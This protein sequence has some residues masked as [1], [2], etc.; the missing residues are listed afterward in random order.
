MITET[1]EVY[2]C[3]Y[4]RK[5][6]QVKRFAELHEERCTKNPNNK[7]A[8]FGCNFLEKKSATLYADSP[9]GGDYEYKR[10]LLFCKKKQIFV[11]PPIV[12]HKN[13]A[14]DLGD[15]FNEPMPKECNLFEDKEWL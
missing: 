5:V 6:Y 10:D 9:V 13:S 8:C 1:K 2:K 11:Y 3:E 14:I 7:R 4:C 15:E 12:E